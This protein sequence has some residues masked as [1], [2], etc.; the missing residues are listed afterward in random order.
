MSVGS[1]ERFFVQFSKN[2]YER[3]GQIKRLNLP[4]SKKLKKSQF[5]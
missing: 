5:F 2:K 4:V 3:V 1:K